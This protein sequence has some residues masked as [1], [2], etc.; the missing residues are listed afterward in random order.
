MNRYMRLSPKC[1]KPKHSTELNTLSYGS[2]TK[3]ILTHQL[4]FGYCFFLSNI[5][6][7]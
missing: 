6:F 2:V 1:V 7:E 4:R 5:F 3:T